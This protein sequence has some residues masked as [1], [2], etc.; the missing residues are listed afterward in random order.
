MSEGAPN[1]QNMFHPWRHLRGLSAVEV[2]W[3]Q[4][5][6]P[7]GKTDGKNRIYMHPHQNQVQRRSTLAHELAHIHLGHTNGCNSH[8]EQQA[9]ILAAQWLIKLPHLI[10]AMKWSTN[11]EE[12][13]DE[14]WVDLPTLDTRLNHLSPEEHQALKT[15]LEEP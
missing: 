12:I 11:L 6:G 1:L 9:N 14:L 7:L 4:K 15:A 13:A 3:T 2:V 5:L 10:N 8:Q